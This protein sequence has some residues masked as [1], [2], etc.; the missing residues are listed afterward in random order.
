MRSRNLRQPPTGSCRRGLT[1]A[2]IAGQSTKPGCNNKRGRMSDAFLL[3]GN[4]D[5]LCGQFAAAL[6]HAEW[7][8]YAT[9]ALILVLSA[10]LFP[11]RDDPDQV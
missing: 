11:P 7:Q 10:L 4:L 9:L 8:L 5:R 1:F 3:L 2:G 6:Q